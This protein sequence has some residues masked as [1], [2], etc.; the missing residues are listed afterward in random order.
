MNHR[1]TLAECIAIVKEAKD[2]LV[3]LTKTPRAF[4]QGILSEYVG[5]MPDDDDSEEPGDMPIFERAIDSVED[6]HEKAH[7]GQDMILQMCGVC[8]EWWAA[9]AICWGIRCVISCV[10]DLM[11]HA[12]LGN[13]D[14]AIAHE[15]RELMFQQ[16]L[17]IHN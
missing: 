11:C 5:T 10:E 12:L 1:S 13:A 2:E 9:D 17:E 6:I 7:R 16:D 15:H 14:L 4:A 8:D 3:A